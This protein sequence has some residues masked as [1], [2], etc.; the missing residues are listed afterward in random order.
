L[1]WRYHHQASS[2]TSFSSLQLGAGAS[3]WKHI[4]IHGV[5]TKLPWKGFSRI[6]LQW[7]QKGRRFPRARGNKMV[8]GPRRE[9]KF[10]RLEPIKNKKGQE[11][12]I[13][14]EI[15]ESNTEWALGAEI[16]LKSLVLVLHLKIWAWKIDKLGFGSR[17]KLQR[18]EGGKN[19]CWTDSASRRWAFMVNPG[20]KTLLSRNWR[21][22]C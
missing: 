8:I 21:G 1:S 18:F 14:D 9:S 4:A 19:G 5:S 17:R 12:K 15:R 3:S 10:W 11:K 22:I 2:C 16:Y 13:W 7:T 6:R 20:I